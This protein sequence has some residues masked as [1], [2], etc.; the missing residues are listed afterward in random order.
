MKIMLVK[1][2]VALWNL[3]ERCVRKVCKGR[4]F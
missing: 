2:A 4:P 1:E 3:F